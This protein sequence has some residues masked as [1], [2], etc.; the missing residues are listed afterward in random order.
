[1]QIKDIVR[2][3]STFFLANLLILLHLSWRIIFHQPIDLL[4]IIMAVFLWLII[5]NPRQSYNL[6]II[7]ILL[8]CELFYTSPFGLEGLS[9]I[10]ALLLANWLLL[11]VFTNRSLIIVFFTG[12]ITMAAYRIVFILLLYLNS[13][14]QN[15]PISISATLINIF[16]NE[17]L[18]TTITLSLFYLISSIFVKRLRPEYILETSRII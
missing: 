13:L 17:T 9:Q 3:I 4:N 8:V 14:I 11:N 16:L 2:K 5:L 12:L 1:M 6:A 18:V 15:H 7:Y 10:L